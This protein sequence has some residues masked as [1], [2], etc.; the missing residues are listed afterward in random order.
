MKNTPAFLLAAIGLA[1]PLVAPAQTAPGLADEEEPLKLSPFE[2]SSAQDHGYRASNSVSATRMNVP[3]SDLPVTINAF[4][5]EF[6]DDQKPRDLID[7]VRFAPGV[8]NGNPEF[9]GGQALFTLRGFDSK[10]NLRNGF[11]GP[12]VLDTVNVARVEVVKGPASLLYGNIEPGGVV[13][14]ITKRPQAELFGSLT[15][16][17]GT[18]G[19]YRTE[20]D[21]NTPIGGKDSPVL[22]RLVGAYD[23]A[24]EFYAPSGRIARSISPSL[25]LKLGDKTQVNMD[26]EVFSSR[27]SPTVMTMQGYFVNGVMV[28]PGTDFGLPWDF[29]AASNQDSR[30]SDART[31]TVDVQTELAGWTLRA[32]YNNFYQLINQFSTANLSGTNPAA[33]V[34]LRRGRIQFDR[35]VDDSWQFEATRTFDLDR[36]KLN[37]LIGYQFGERSS[38][39]S[40][41]N[42]LPPL[43]ATWDLLDPSTWNRDFNIDLNAI[44]NANPFRIEDERDG[45]YA[46]AHFSTL[47]EKLHVLAGLRYST[48]DSVTITRNNAGVESRSGILHAKE[49]SPQFGVLY[50]VAPA[51]SVFASYSKSFRP[52]GGS[53]TINNVAGAAAKEPLIGE[54]Y[55]VGFKFNF[56]DGRF[57]ANLALF[58]LDYT[59]TVTQ[60]VVGTDPITNNVI[61][62]QTQDGKDR[63]KGVELDYLWIPNDHWQIYGTYAYLDSYAVTNTTPALIGV[64]RGNTSKHTANLFVKYRFTEGPLKGFS[65]AG[66]PSY[67]GPRRGS[68]SWPYYYD[69]ALVF[70]LLA[71]YGWERGGQHYSV[72]LSVKN[73]LDEK[74]YDSSSTTRGDPRRVSLSFAIKF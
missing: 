52:E 38:S 29:N 53:L 21:I 13:N 33:P 71:S 8:T 63:S 19:Y 42:M 6:I 14:Y 7:I 36:G 25:T 46:V 45:V 48:A 49:T 72:D 23:N 44:P 68:A 62:T 57:S 5:Q 43:P 4:T 20:A 41:R 54:G 37:F 69:S 32:A 2:V 22:F 10:A 16:A 18:D 26:Y 67:S 30:D 39:G 70:N 56:A 61:I 17:I 11:V 73:V 35:R 24:A 50:Q 28:G 9:V 1:L 47:Q 31:W 65:L 74:Y 64:Q 12:A 40:Q 58:T 55:D 27:E 66:G 59:G 15:Q 34:V 3:L 60:R 51:V